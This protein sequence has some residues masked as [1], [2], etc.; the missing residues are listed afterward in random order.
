VDRG[1]AISQTED[2]LAKK[3]TISRTPDDIALALMGAERELKQPPSGKRETVQIS[4]RQIV[5]RPEL[6]QPRGFSKGT[7][8][9]G[10]VTKLVKRIAA[11]GELEPPLVVKLGR[12]WVCVD[13]H[14]RIAAY[15]KHHGWDWNGDIR[16]YWF[17]GTAREAVDESVRLN[18][19]VKLE[20]RR[21]DRYEAAWQR[22]VLGWGSKS[23]IHR[24]TG[25]S[26]GLIAMMR[27]VVEAHR[28]SDTFG[29]E[30]RAKLPSIKD[31]TW[32]EARG[33]YVNLTP[34]EWDHREA[35]AKLARILRNRMHGKLS[36]NKLVTAYALA[37]YD[38]D[39]P[40]PLATALRQVAATT[41][42]EDDGELQDDLRADTLTYEPAD[43]LL[44]EIDR[45]RGTQQRTA[46]RISSIE[47]ELKR[48]GDNPV[49]APHGTNADEE[50]TQG[51]AAVA[52]DATPD[53][54]R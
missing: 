52:L 25:V 16:C 39:L 15:M 34:A 44:A 48:R 41:T 43:E 31:A 14:H 30:L 54:G 17:A 37:L 32:T 24:L 50:A 7:L 47:E 53:N 22:I 46:G 1:R 35:A 5:T 13:G 9:T 40:G 20:M 10:F 18:D 6:F 23:E 36:E 3:A 27:R 38:P 2:E 12:K 51:L 42:A 29:K 26:D 28:R 49:A 11:R 21:G 45:L 8:D 19:V 33:A 4:P